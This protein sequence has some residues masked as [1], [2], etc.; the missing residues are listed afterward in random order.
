MSGITSNTH[1]VV[2]KTP[3]QSVLKDPFTQSNQAVGVPCLVQGHTAG[4][5]QGWDPPTRAQL[6]AGFRQ[7]S[8][9]QKIA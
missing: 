1:M 7:S 4:E 3:H 8:F 5:G 6:H 9:A 2:L